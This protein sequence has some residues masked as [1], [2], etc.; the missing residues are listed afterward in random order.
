V[1]T[2]TSSYLYKEGLGRPII[3][4]TIRTN[5]IIPVSS[6][7]FLTK[8]SQSPKGR[9]LRR[10]YISDFS[11]RFQSAW[12]T[13]VELIQPL[14]HLNAS[15]LLSYNGIR[16]RLLGYDPVNFNSCFGILLIRLRSLKHEFLSLCVIVSCSYYLKAWIFII[17]CD[18]Y[19]S[20]FN[21]FM[22]YQFNH[23]TMI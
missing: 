9:V 18:I 2:L 12:A 3:Y 14:P 11:N 4:T 20:C 15:P 13:T 22:I 6:T 10:D 5:W 19:A 17:V 1:A 7:L 8:T 21:F 16:A 23:V